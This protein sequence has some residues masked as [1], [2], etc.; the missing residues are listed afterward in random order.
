MPKKKW[1]VIIDWI[2]SDVSDA[3]E[4]T[5]FAENAAEAK[6]KARARWE[7]MFPP[8]FPNCKIEKVWILTSSKERLLGF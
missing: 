7:A 5:V 6:A 2:D 3:D 1:I 4:F 8:Q